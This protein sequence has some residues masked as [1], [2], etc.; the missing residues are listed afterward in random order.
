MT[1]PA[2]LA[3]DVR[4]GRR[5]PAPATPD[6]VLARHVLES[7][8][9]HRR[10]RRTS[11]HDQ[12]RPAGPRRATGPTTGP[13]RAP[14]W[15]AAPPPTS[16]RP[17]A[18][19]GR[20]HIMGI[21]GA[22]MSGAGPHPAR[23]RRARSAAA[24]PR[25]STTVAGPARAR[26]RRCTIGHSAEHLARRRHVRLHHRDQP[27]TTEFV[28]ARAQR[29]AGAA[30]RGRAGRRRW[31]TSARVAVAGTHGKTSTTSL[32]TVGAQALRRRPVLR[33]RRQPL[34]DAARTRTS[35]PASWPSSRPTRATARSCSCARPPRWS[36]TSRP[37]TSRTTATSRASSGRSSS[38]STGSTPTGCCSICADDAGR[39]RGSPSYARAHRAPGA[40]LRRRPP[41]PTCGSRD[42]VT[43]AGDAVEF[44]VA[45]RPSERAA[46]GVG[47]LIGEHM[48]LNA[49]AALVMAAELG[50]DLDTV[51]RAVGRLRRRAPPLRV[52]RRGRRRPRLRRLR[53]PPDRDR[54]RAARGRR[55]AV[56]GGGRLIA[57]FQPGTYSRTQTF[58]REF[59]DAHGA[60]RR[61]RRAWT[62][63]RRAR[64]RSRASPAPP[65]ADLIA[66]PA[67]QVVYE[68]RYAAVPRARRR[69]WPGPATWW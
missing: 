49:A 4:G 56:A 52:A 14:R 46:V 27:A 1:D 2:R 54:G 40:H 65:S 18:D 8:P 24:R 32:L 61:R 37:T 5:S 63:S 19:L 38:S 30:P 21:A 51:G 60:G 26:R 11:P 31:R 34:R 12:R 15:C 36:P 53:P 50:L 43:T 10:G 58:A 20:V 59:A 39:A 47:A 16:C 64:N 17:L 9:R 45:G 69:R 42:I 67:E 48:A 28:A 55:P 33:H 7:S 35:A 22:G 13:R 68:P 57:V 3:G 23:A 25:D 62:S 41:T 29:H 44:T 6:V 66:L